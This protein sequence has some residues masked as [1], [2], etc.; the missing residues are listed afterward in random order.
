MVDHNHQSDS[1]PR[2]DVSL[3]IDGFTAQEIEHLRKNDELVEQE[4]RAALHRVLQSRRYGKSAALPRL[5]PVGKKEG[6]KARKAFHFVR[7]FRFKTASGQNQDQDKAER[8]RSENDRAIPP[9]LARFVKTIEPSFETLT[10]KDAA[11]ML[12]VAPNTLKTRIRQGK[13]LA[14]KGV[15]SG[16]IIPAEQ[17]TDRRTVLPGIEEVIGLLGD[18]EIAWTFLTRQQPFGD[19]VDRPLNRLKGGHVADVIST[20]KGYGTDF[21]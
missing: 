21:T 13:V 15:K 7:R 1:L 8:G 9:A 16:Y 14:W 19:E 20:A 4:M 17:F 10:I 3:Y 11:A 5:P 12:A 18:P 2:H 6:K